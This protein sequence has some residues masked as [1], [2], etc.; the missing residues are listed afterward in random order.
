MAIFCFVL[1]SFHKE[2]QKN[3]DAV[4][5]EQNSIPSNETLRE[6]FNFTI[7]PILYSHSLDILFEYN[8]ILGSTKKLFT[9]I[10]HAFCVG[11]F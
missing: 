3:D 11:C 6:N 7:L 1:I 5:L 8:T 10:G 4:S 9:I 2:I